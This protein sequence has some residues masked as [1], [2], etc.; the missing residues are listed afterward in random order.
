MTIE[1]GLKQFLSEGLGTNRIWFSRAPQ[2]LPAPIEDDYVVFYRIAVTPEHTHAGPSPVI[3][4][5]F[6]FSVVSK[7]QS[8]GAA[9]ADR[10]RRRLNGYRGFMGDVN[11]FGSFWQGETYSYTTETTPPLHQFSV[12]IQVRYREV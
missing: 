3:S 2:T 9:L 11:T 7:S 1:D 5:L 10:L 12:D 6:Q 8:S 4:R